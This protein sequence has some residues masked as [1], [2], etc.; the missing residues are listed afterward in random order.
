MVRVTGAKVHVAERLV[1]VTERLVDETVAMVR[2]KEHWVA[3]AEA[4]VCV[5]EAF[6]HDEEKKNQQIH[7]PLSIRRASEIRTMS[8]TSSEL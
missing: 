4:K 5:T 1:R 8:R 6:S 2:V 3:V 7:T